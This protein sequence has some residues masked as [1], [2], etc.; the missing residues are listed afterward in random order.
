MINVGLY[1][2]FD[3][4]ADSYLHAVFNSHLMLLSLIPT[5]KSAWQAGQKAVQ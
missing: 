3:P 5:E 4:T 1:R 2:S